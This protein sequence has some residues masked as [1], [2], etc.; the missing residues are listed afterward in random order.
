MRRFHLILLAI[1]LCGLGLRIGAVTGEN[2]RFSPTGYDDGVYYSASAL[3]LRGVLPYRDFVFV[4]PPA[5][6]YV[7]AA[8]SWMPDPAIGFAAARVLAGLA[9][10]ASIVLLGLIVARASTPAGGLVAA[11]LY[12][13]YPDAVVAERSP[14]LEPFL[15][16]FCLLSAW[17]WLS[18][19][20]DGSV[21]RPFVAGVAAGLACAVKLWAGVWVIAAVLAVGRRHFRDALLF[22][23]GG[24]AAGI[25]ALAPLALPAPRAFFEQTLRFQLSRP[26]DGVM[27]VAGRLRDIA[28][29]GHR[30]A[31]ALAL[32]ALVLIV[33]RRQL[34]PAQR[35]FAIAML[36]T[37]A[38]FLASSSYW[39]HYN[40]HLAAS[41]C[42]MAGLGA[43]MLVGFLPRRRGLATAVLMVVAIAV[44]YGTI[45]GMARGMRGRSPELMTAAH[46][47]EQNVPKGARFFAFD[48]S[49]SLITSR[50]PDCCD[51]APPVV[52]SYGLMLLNAVQGGRTFPDTG[53]AFRGGA[54]QPEMRARLGA[55]EFVLLGG[56]GQWQ[57]DEP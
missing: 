47:I 12:A 34:A 30:A 20:D 36:L 51:G 25:L 4:H 35:F 54:P 7:L 39:N 38:G 13:V 1:A 8:T 49:W 11:L 9:G 48:P 32:I 21:R 41:Q 46:V 56:R 52:D 45:R 53:Q 42:A 18:R 14:Y 50:L 5:L 16:L 22:V 37:V 29:S 23:A 28:G 24:A 6:L 17:L 40:S 26:P 31:T 44:D 55:S 19:R 43:A 2:A 15:N 27:E 3:L 10:A 57:L 33:V